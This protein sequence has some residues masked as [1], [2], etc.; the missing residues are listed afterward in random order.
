MPFW[1][2]TIRQKTGAGIV[3]GGLLLA[4]TE[5]ESSGIGSQHSAQCL[6]QVDGQWAAAEISAVRQP[7]A[8]RTQH[9]LDELWYS[10]GGEHE[11]SSH[12]FFTQTVQNCSLGER[13]SLGKPDRFFEGCDGCLTVRRWASVYLPLRGGLT[14]DVFTFLLTSAPTAAD[15]IQRM[16]HFHSFGSQQG[17]SAFS[18][19]SNLHSRCVSLSWV[20]GLLPLTSAHEKL[21]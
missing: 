14:I 10:T 9:S 18:H 7:W 6:P 12:I 19:T 21:R 20:W 2:F 17:I 16:K 5:Q 13:L 1:V 11:F 15:F 4:K 3:G 8:Q